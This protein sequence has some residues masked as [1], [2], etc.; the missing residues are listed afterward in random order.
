[1]KE[2]IEIGEEL[3]LQK[4]MAECTFRPQIEVDTVPSNGEP[5]PPVWER[6]L[7]YDK[8]Q[9]IE[10]REKLKEQ[11]E[12]QE[13][14]F[15][16]EVKS[17]DALLMKRSPSSNVFDRLTGS[18]TSPLDP[19]RPA[20]ITRRPSNSPGRQS[21]NAK[22]PSVGRI[23]KSTKFSLPVQRKKLSRTHS[24]SQPSSVNKPTMKRSTSFS[25]SSSPTISTADVLSCLVGGTDTCSRNATM[26]QSVTENYES[27]SAE[28]NAKLRNYNSEEGL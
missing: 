17:P 15:K 10:E 5:A 7:S 23:I 3:R 18:N 6:L 1:M 4:E 9:V 16:P 27:W 28:L 24:I 19:A 11:L 25:G 13:C 26:P 22:N 12:M 8:A 21:P 2:K 20:F 14:T